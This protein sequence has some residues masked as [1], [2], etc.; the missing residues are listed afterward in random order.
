MCVEVTVA[1]AQGDLL[2]KYGHS[3]R[4]A[5]V[6]LKWMNRKSYKVVLSPFLV[7]VLEVA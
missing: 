5:L 1:R 2:Q 7:F 6:Q 4:P 3:A